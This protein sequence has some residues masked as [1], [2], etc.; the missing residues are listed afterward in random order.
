MEHELVP[1]FL[2]FLLMAGLRALR[3][4]CEVGRIVAL[5]LQ[6]YWGPRLGF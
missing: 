1:G 5:L 2:E 6:P 4:L 3:A